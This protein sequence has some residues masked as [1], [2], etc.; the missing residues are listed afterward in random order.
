[1]AETPKKDPRK[2]ERDR[3]LHE[4]E[5]QERQDDL[6]TALKLYGSV[7]NALSE[8]LP[9]LDKARA[10]T[11]QLRQLCVKNPVLR[12]AMV[13]RRLAVPAV[14]TDLRDL[15]FKLSIIARSIE[16]ASLSRRSELEEVIRDPGLLR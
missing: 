9:I 14:G 6:E 7:S 2:E 15:H 4:R 13:S 11:E 1:V 8:A 10:D 3:K 5:L 12:A 16:R